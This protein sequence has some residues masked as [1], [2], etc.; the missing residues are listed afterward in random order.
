MSNLTIA[1]LI[2]TSLLV[3]TIAII[4]RSLYRADTHN[5]AK[6]VSKIK[7]VCGHSPLTWNGGVW[8]VDGPYHIPPDFVNHIHDLPDTD[9]SVGESGYV[10]DC[11][12]CNLE[13]YFTQDGHLHS[14]KDSERAAG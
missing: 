7:C 1:I 13:L 10:F 11:P 2:A 14:V 12:S 4:G 8:I 9:T 5:V 6:L 3:G